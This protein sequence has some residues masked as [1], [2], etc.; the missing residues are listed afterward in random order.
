[1]AK[2]TRKTQPLS[3]FV[4]PGHARLVLVAGECPTGLTFGLS[5]GSHDA[6]REGAPILLSEDTTV[7]PSHATFAYRGDSLQ[8]SDKGS[9]NGVYVRVRAPRALE[10]GDWF[11]VGGQFFRFHVVDQRDEYPSADGTLHFISPKRAASFRVV[12]ILDGGRTGLSMVASNDELT[13]GGEGCN[14]AFTADTH[15][16]ARHARISRNSSGGF[17]IEDTGSTNGTYVRIRGKETLSHGD[18]VYVGNELLRVEIT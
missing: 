1:M 12:Q 10:D 15:L 11:R 7:S 2:Q 5:G 9:L 18:F 16:S 17:S 4:T 3:P 6:G 14:V 8:V 13:I